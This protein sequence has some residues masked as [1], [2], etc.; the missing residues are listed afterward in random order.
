MPV[1]A[2]VVNVPSGA[3]AHD[4]VVVRVGDEEAA[5]RQRSD[6]VRRVEPC[7]RRDGRDRAVRGDAADPRVARVGDQKAAVRAAVTPRRAGSAAPRAQE[8]PSPEK[9]GVPV[10]ATVVMTPVG[11]IRRTRWL[12]ESGKRIAAVG[13]RGDAARRRDLRRRRR[14]AVSREAECPRAGDGRD[15]AVRSHPPDAVV[16]RCPRAPCCRPEAT[17]RRGRG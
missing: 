2:T 15:D 6:R 9:P 11:E 17:R 8:P 10:P 14:A 12:P 5:V 3:D 13:E 1:P 4:A 16:A 7:V